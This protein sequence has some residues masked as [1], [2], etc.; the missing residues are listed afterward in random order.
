MVSRPFGGNGSFKGFTNVVTKGP[1]WVL[2]V[3]CRWS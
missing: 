2:P 1:G 3:A